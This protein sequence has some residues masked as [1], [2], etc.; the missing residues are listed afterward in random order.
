M[1]GN[2]PAPEIAAAQQGLSPVWPWRTLIGPAAR[3]VTFPINAVSCKGRQEDHL[4]SRPG[5]NKKKL[6]TNRFII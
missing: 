6:R 5:I 1:G 2:W 4:L 3:I